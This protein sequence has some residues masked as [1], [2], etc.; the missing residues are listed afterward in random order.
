MGGPHT[1][2][3]EEIY[4]MFFSITEIKPYTNLVKLEDAYEY[5][6]Y[7]WWQS[8]YRQLFRTWLNP[9]M[10]TLESQNLVVNPLNKGFADLHIKPISMGT[11]VHDLVSD[12]YW[13]YN[14]HEVNRR[15]GANN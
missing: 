9:E 4:E 1:Y 10:M 15:E 5:Y 12:V 11:K 13:L 8:A 2:T 3:Y 7:K 6:H 14:S